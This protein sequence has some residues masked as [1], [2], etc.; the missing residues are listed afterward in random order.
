MDK[1]SKN[2]INKVNYKTENKIDDFVG[3]TYKKSEDKYILAERRY[4]FI[5]KNYAM[6]S[7][8]INKISFGVYGRFEQEFSR[9]FDKYEEDITK[10]ALFLKSN[11]V[12]G[13]EYIIEKWDKF[14]KKVNFRLEENSLNKLYPYR[15]ML[16]TAG[17]LPVDI[18]D[19]TVTKGAKCELKRI[20]DLFPINSMKEIQYF[21]DEYYNCYSYDVGD[22]KYRESPI[23][24][25]ENNVSL[26]FKD[27]VREYLRI[28]GIQYI[29]NAE[30]F[31]VV[32][33][34]KE[35][36][37]LQ[38]YVAQNPRGFSKIIMFKPNRNS[39]NVK[40]ITF[41][42][43]I[44]EDNIQNNGNMKWG[45]ELEEAY[46]GI[47]AG[48]YFPIFSHCHALVTGSSG[49]GKSTATLWL[50]AN[51]LNS[52]PNSVFIA[53]FKGNREWKFLSDYPFYYVGDKCL[54]G[55]RKFYHLFKQAQL[56]DTVP[57]KQKLLIFDEYPAFIQHLTMMDKLNKSK[58]LIEAQSM[59]MEILAMGRSL[60]YGLWI[61]A[62]RPDANLFS[63]GSRDNFMITIALGNI[64]KDHQRMI[65]NGYDLPAER[66]YQPGE[67]LL[68]ADGYR[69][70]EVKYPL[71][72]DV[73]E[74][75]RKISHLLMQNCL[76]DAEGIGE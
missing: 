19:Y 70:T 14:E 63:N 44:H 46:R 53:D 8:F 31:V 29:T 13:L 48:I 65:C 76:E 18:D 51:F 6:C 9:W 21:N 28:Y 64:S 2:Q 27:V 50:L 39:S 55:I 42:E 10:S 58:Q 7:K 66:I 60:G 40:K 30:N 26:V 57:A 16:G 41:E 36:H 43:K 73:E 4:Q 17:L 54:D 3:E 11:I 47:K 37:L 1:F 72:S 52:A 23:E 5:E 12:Q 61:L 34:D 38:A 24:E 68:C 49:T 25:I 22:Y 45:Y 32:N 75:K 74:W 35:K 71:L 69:V 56:N 59:I 15:I 67:G 33:Y 62:Q 20:D